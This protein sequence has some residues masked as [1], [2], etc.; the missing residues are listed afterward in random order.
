M[1]LVQARG[2]FAESMIAGA[3]KE[4]LRKRIEEI[5]FDVARFADLRSVTENRLK[6][7]VAAGYHADMDW[8]AR[9]I[10][11]RLD[12]SLVLDGCCSIVMMGVN[13]LPD[14]GEVARSQTGFAKYSLYRDY[15]DTVLLGLK[16][17]GEVLESEF[18]LGKGDY[19]YY[20]DTGPVMERG[21]AA[22]A[23]LGWQGKNGMLI[24]REHGNWLLL[25]SVLV[26]LEI[27]PDG[28]LKKR[29]SADDQAKAELGLLCGKCTRCMDA[30]PTGAIVEPGILDTRKC[31]SYQTIENKGAIPRELR[32]KMGGRVYGCDI[33]LDACP[34]NRFAKAGR[35][36]LLEARYEASELGLL[37]LLRMEIEQFREVFR[38]MPQKRTK[39]RGLK[40]NACVA[41]GNLLRCEDWWPAN[42]RRRDE[43]LEAV[44]GEVLRLAGEDEEP[45]VR[46]HAVWAVYELFGD[47]A[48]EMLAEV[49]ERETDAGVLAEYR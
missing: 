19:R 14:E 15:H 7:W 28:P 36:Q 24:S 41:A 4:D 18:G 35:L 48:A 47:A 43:F 3:A 11:K 10:E 17:F 13:Y 29:E 27:E 44:K 21:W 6:E 42:G 8:L 46:G 12:P 1:P 39:L 33:C 38:K 31:I 34:W 49:K 16:A 30:C 32:A 22:T 45:L 23:G 26:K 2:G 40:R 25:A 9:S 37:D 20:V 5:G